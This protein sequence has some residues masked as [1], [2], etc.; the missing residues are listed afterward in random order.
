MATNYESAIPADLLADMQAV[1]E[2]V[3]AGRPVAP[4]V[5]RR[6][7][8]R[9]EKARQENLDQHGVRAVAV[10]L[11]R[12]VRGEAD[13][14]NGHATGGGEPP[15]ADFLEPVRY[16]WTEAAYEARQALKRYSEQTHADY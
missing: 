12:E 9:S 5:A 14:A 16:E 4:E 15:V 6:I 3:A 8:E 7:R 2:A 10:D 13:G 1:V 11:I